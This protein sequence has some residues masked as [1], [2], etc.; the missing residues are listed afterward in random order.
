MNIATSIQDSPP[1]HLVR[2]VAST[3]VG[4]YAAYVIHGLL[5]PDLLRPSGTEADQHRLLPGDE[6]VSAPDWCTTFSEIIHA[7]RES[8]WPWLLQMGYGADHVVPEL[9][10]LLVG[11]VLPDGPRTAEGFGVWTVRRLEAPGVMVL[12]SKRNPLTGRERKDETSPE[13]YLDCSWAFALEEMDERTS[14]LIVR[15]RAR[16][17]GVA[18]ARL[19][20]KVARMFFG[21]GDT[22]MERTLL[23]GIRARAERAYAM[24]EH[25]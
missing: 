12:T 3:A 4:T 18:K 22:V 25:N 1:A 24:S 8:V 13:P 14:R 20:A 7:P 2:R 9:Q 16:V 10:G 11:D 15:V 17:C 23:E 6:L 21:V 19:V 5:H